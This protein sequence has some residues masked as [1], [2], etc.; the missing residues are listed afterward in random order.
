MDTTVIPANL[1][2]DQHASQELHEQEETLDFIE[3]WKSIS[4]RK[5]AILA[6]GVAVA[7]MAAVI[8][9]VMTPVYR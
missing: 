7:M 1:N 8:V 6:F 3:Y 2:F 9:F 5:W 4:K